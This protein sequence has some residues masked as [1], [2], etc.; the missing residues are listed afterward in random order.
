MGQGGRAARADQI[1]CTTG[2]SDRSEEPV[3]DNAS[4]V[5]PPTGPRGRRRS[6]R[7][8]RPGPFVR[9]VRPQPPR[10]AAEWNLPRL[11]HAARGTSGQDAPGARKAPGRR[12]HGHR[13]RL[14]PPLRLQ[15]PRAR[16]RRPLPRARDARR[17]LRAQGPAALRR[18]QLRLPD[19]LRQF[20]HLGGSDLGSAVLRPAVRRLSGCVGRFAAFILLLSLIGLLRLHH[21]LRKP[22]RKQADLAAAHW[23]NVEVLVA[24]P[25]PPQQ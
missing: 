10:L 25:P 3:S 22:L 14:L 12:R 19:R 4:H 18:T 1:A 13:R 23:H 15:P 16:A 7:V 9:T 21:R 5:A 6:G 20:L 11:Q 24:A 2:A 17:A 8:D